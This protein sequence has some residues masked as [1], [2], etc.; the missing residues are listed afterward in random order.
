[1]SR[2]NKKEQ[3]RVGKRLHTDSFE[4]IPIMTWVII[5]QRLELKPYQLIDKIVRTQ[6]EQ[7]LHEEYISKKNDAG[8]KVHVIERTYLPPRTGQELDPEKW[9]GRIE[10]SI[11][12]DYSFW[13]EQNGMKKYSFTAIDNSKLLLEKMEAILT[14]YKKGCTKQ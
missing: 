11:Q 13:L 9:Y 1:M 12:R 3:Y 2:K 5:A 14:M 8:Q 6:D 10:D 4:S 7:G